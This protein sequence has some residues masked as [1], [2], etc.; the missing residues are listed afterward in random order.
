MNYKHENVTD[1]LIELVRT[2][3]MLYDVN[4]ADF[5][6]I[7][8]KDNIWTRIAATLNFD[9]GKKLFSQYFFSLHFSIGKEVKNMWSKLRNC[10]RDAIRRRNRG[11]STKKVWRYQKQM[12]FLL[13]FMT[14]GGQPQKSTSILDDEQESDEDFKETKVEEIFIDDSVTAQSAA[15]DQSIKMDDSL[16][17]D[18]LQT[19]TNIKPN[20]HKEISQ[21]DHL[22]HFFM[23]MYKITRN[24]PLR[25]QINV[26]NQIYQTVSTAETELLG[27]Q[28][29]LENSNQPGEAATDSWF[30]HVLIQPISSS[31]PQ[32][33]L[34]NT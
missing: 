34:N 16:D 13:P 7:K 29:E 15:L 18:I 33:P 3:R 14:S 28:S 12:D 27:I 30:T 19:A 23:A 24:L 5:L 10:H 2:Q 20:K 31:P 6:N 21:N 26:R 1:T 8:L 9:S 25:Q 22:Y 11:L 32:S 4:H 17:S